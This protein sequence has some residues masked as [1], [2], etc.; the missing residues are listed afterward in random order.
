MASRRFVR[1]GSQPQDGGQIPSASLLPKERA[2]MRRFLSLAVKIAVSLAL[3]YVA[4]ARVDLGALGARLQQ[5]NVFWL[6]AL[7]LTLAAQI[8]L[9][10]LRWR[11]IALQCGA[12]MTI[13][14]TMRYMLIASF[15]N[16]TLP[17][18]IGGDAVRVWLLSRTGAG[19][20]AAAYSVIVDRVFGL[21][22]LVAIVVVGMP[23]LLD[24]VRDPIG[25]ASVVLVDGAAL[26]GTAVFLILGRVRWHW[27]DR[28]WITRHVTGTAAV[29][30]DVVSSWRVA[31][32]VIGISVVSHLLTVTAIWSAA[33]SVAAPFEF[34]QALLL[35][36][37]VIMVSTVPI[38]IAGWGVR[39]GAMM[40]AFAYGGLLNSDGLIVSIIYGAA[41]FAIGA[42]CGLVWIL[43]ADHRIG[44]ADE[45]ERISKNEP[46]TLPDVR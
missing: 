19:W 42:I 2:A 8:V 36:P 37:T 3:L 35:V 22:V 30:F 44:I 27:L 12:Q 1:A 13:P 4:F 28:W 23:W 9:A 5:A 38:S 40:T 15:F 17:S 18:T 31:N 16:Q 41:L 32:I 10:G 14:S 25:R 26:A 46:R 21:A 45:E 29:A 34:W 39:E 43:G 24:L 11:Q 33:R 20:K 7:M 6:V